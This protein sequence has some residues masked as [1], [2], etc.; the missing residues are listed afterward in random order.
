MLH[1]H[2][3]DGIPIWGVYGAAL[4]LFLVSIEAAYRLG[5]RR[6]DGSDT[7]HSGNTLG[8]IFAL[9]GFLLAFTFGM[10]GSQ[11]NARRQLVLEDANAIGTAYLRAAQLPDSYRLNTRALL[12]DYVSDRHIV[13]VETLGARTARW[14]QLQERLWAEATA[15]AETHPTP[16][17]SLFIQSLN[18]MFDIHARR[19]TI[20]LW[21]RIPP[22]IFVTLAFLSVLIMASL[23]Y[24]LGLSGRR[25]IVP[26]FLL[27]LTYATVFLLVIDLDRP[28]Q[29][30]FRVSQQPMIDLRQSMGIDAEP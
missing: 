12:R 16:I 7:P 24:V 28:E 8:A 15:A 21:T 5:H 22:M 11:Y 29:G 9:V 27:V 19:K 2:I 1:D 18:E 20:T 30:L 17:T 14:E 6:R 26:T 13:D 4:L 3:L 25:H 23:G 10:A